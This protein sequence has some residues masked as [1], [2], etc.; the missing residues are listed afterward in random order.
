[1]SG[2]QKRICLARFAH[3]IISL[4]RH[5]ERLLRADPDDPDGIRILIKEQGEIE[6]IGQGYAKSFLNTHPFDEF[7]LCRTN[8]DSLVEAKIR[9]ILADEWI[10]GKS[11]RAVIPL[12]KFIDLICEACEPLVRT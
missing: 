4:H 9:H 8:F 5:L 2:P 10:D 6:Y 12:P 7:P 3:F 11:N 1:M